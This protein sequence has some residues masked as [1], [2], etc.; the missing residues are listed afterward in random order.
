M[1]TRAQKLA[2]NNHKLATKVLH[3]EK[4]RDEL[5]A[6]VTEMRGLIEVSTSNPLRLDSGDYYVIPVHL[7]RKYMANDEG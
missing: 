6:M 5:A 1:G 7:A 4:E 2:D 3:L